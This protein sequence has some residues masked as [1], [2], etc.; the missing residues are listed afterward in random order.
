MITVTLLFVGGRDEDAAEEESDEE[1]EENRETRCDE[2]R[3]LF[4]RS[5]ELTDA[6]MSG[7]DR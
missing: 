6:R 2:K 7:G 4:N 1:E 3:W 5:I